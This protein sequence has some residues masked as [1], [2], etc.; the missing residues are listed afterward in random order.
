M[1]L[2]KILLVAG[3]ILI[4]NRIVRYGT[5]G[6]GPDS[7]KQA[8]RGA[9]SGGKPARVQCPW[10]GSWNISQYRDLRGI[11]W[12]LILLTLGLILLIMPVFPRVNKC[13]SCGKRWSFGKKQ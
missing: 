6:R 9:R 8:I 4:I 11:Y 3:V 12:F 1:F 2:W 10:C 5:I 13:N 7:G